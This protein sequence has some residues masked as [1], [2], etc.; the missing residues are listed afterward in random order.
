MYQDGTIESFD[1]NGNRVAPKLKDKPEANSLIAKELV[2]RINKYI[3]KGL[4]VPQEYIDALPQKDLDA[5]NKT[6]GLKLK[7]SK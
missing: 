4:I 5:I 6:H 3:E 1:K 7:K 2:T